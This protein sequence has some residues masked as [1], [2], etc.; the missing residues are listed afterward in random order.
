MEE[1]TSLIRAIKAS[2][3]WETVIFLACICLIISVAEN[4]VNFNHYGSTK[5][6]IIA[7]ITFL[8]IKWSLDIFKF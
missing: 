2:V 1:L 7:I 6:G 4:S 8:A 5:L 3:T